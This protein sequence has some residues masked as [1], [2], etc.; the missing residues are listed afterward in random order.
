MPK[1]VKW[2]KTATKGL[3]Y[4]FHPT[5]TRK[6]GL[7]TERDIFYQYRHVANGQRFEEGLG[8]LFE[9][10]TLEKA[11]AK[12]HELKENKTLGVG[13]ATLQAKRA[14][15][16][17][18]ELAQKRA[19]LEEQKKNITFDEVWKK[20]LPFC[21]VEKK[22]RRGWMREVSLYNRYIQP[23]IGKLPM[24]SIAP[25]HLERMKKSMMDLKL[26]PRTITYAL[27]VTRQVFNY[28]IRNELFAGKNPVSQV[29]KPT[30][31]NKRAR[32]F[33]LADAE[34]LLTEL[35]KRDE[36]VYG[37]ALLSFRCGLRAAEILRLTW[38]AI[39]FENEQ[40]H[41][42][43][44]KSGRNRFAFMTE[45]VKRLLADRLKITT[46]QGPNDLIFRRTDNPYFE[47]PRLFQKTVDEMGF[48]IGYTDRRQRLVFHSCRHSFASWHAAAGTDLHI[49]QKLLGH[50]TFAMVL[51]Y[52]HLKPDTLKAA[53]KKLELIQMGENQQKIQQI[54]GTRN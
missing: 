50:E 34:N 54:K 42:M 3:R 47:I 40:I 7:K 35:K 51:R 16:K 52:A 21:Q 43:D 33:S 19:E 11:I 44:T 12:V 31:D 53:V 20:Y 22:N 1:H 36:D 26:A 30:A 29:N 9:G 25:F 45:D 49:L 14:K 46:D 32:F 18:E 41:I 17:K 38:G 28:A 37:M 13:P 5:R 6:K 39:D 48:N 2:V 10:M 23:T 4:R 15:Q 24:V 8:W 27:A